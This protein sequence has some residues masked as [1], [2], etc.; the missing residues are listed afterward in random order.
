MSDTVR[1]P[2][3]YNTGTIEVINVIEDWRLN[4]N[5]G[6]VLKYLARAPHKGKHL[7][8]LQKAREYL[9]FEIARVQRSLVTP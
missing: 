2:K 9:D 4:F 5:E 7:E 8:D 3:H 1:H 6:N